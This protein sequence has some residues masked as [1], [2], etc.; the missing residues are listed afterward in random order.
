VA[1]G[2]DE[3]WRRLCAAIGRPEWAA[4]EGWA[5][6]PGRVLHRAAVVAA[7]AGRFRERPRAEWLERLRE[8]RVP[9][10]PVRD[11]AEVMADP[12]LRA[13][14]LLRRAALPGPA[15]VP[16]DLLA[17]PW[18]V[19]G[20]RPPLGLPPPRLGEHTAGFLERFGG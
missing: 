6:N 4:R 3:Q 7:L 1:V 15:A 17:L 20:A 19:D 5:A 10:G 14:D 11:M 18:R 16:V 8:A 12:A 13:R 9:A 2:N